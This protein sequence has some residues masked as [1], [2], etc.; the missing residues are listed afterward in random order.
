MRG[1]RFGYHTM[2]RANKSLVYASY[3]G[4]PTVYLVGS[5]GAAWWFYDGAWK[6]ADGPDVYVNAAVMTKAAFDER[7]GQLFAMTTREKYMKEIS[8]NPR[9]REA[10][11]SSSFIVLVLEPNR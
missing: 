4:R 2:Q 5:G 7:F 1:D 8:T 10:E 3:E 9:F 11:K 6:E